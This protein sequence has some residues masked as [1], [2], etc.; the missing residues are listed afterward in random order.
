ML[1]EREMCT[2]PVAICEG[3]STNDI[4]GGVTY[5]FSNHSYCLIMIDNI[6]I[7]EKVCIYIYIY[8]YVFTERILSY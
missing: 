2:S 3:G 1:E 6:E 4:F 5:D 7:I 8:T